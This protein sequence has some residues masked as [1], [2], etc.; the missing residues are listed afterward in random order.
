M[1]F[2]VSQ[3][4]APTRSALLT[5]RHEFRNGVTHTIA[6]RERLSLDAVTLAQGLGKC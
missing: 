4:C 6:E 3:T 5:G 1:D 2:H